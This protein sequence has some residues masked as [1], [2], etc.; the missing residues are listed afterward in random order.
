[1]ILT[2]IELKLD[3]W[4]PKA[5]IS[6]ASG[7]GNWATVA[8]CSSGLSAPERESWESRLKALDARHLAEYVPYLQLIQYMDQ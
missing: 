8:L 4:E 5:G 7:P 1:M 6:L 2:K 3:D